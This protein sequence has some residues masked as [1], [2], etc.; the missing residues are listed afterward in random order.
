MGATAAAAAAVQLPKIGLCWL[1][2]LRRDLVDSQET[3][4]QSVG[5]SVVRSVL[6]VV[7]VFL[8]AIDIR[9]PHRGR[10]FLCGRPEDELIDTI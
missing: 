8:S 9:G 2:V 5:R 10:G 6:C 1:A 4:G 3:L 7:Q